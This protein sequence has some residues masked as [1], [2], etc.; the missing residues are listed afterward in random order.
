MKSWGSWDWRGETGSKIYFVTSSAAP[1][2]RVVMKTHSTLKRLLLPSALLLA[3]AASS[4]AAVSLSSY[5]YVGWGYLHPGYTS[6]SGTSTASHSDGFNDEFMGIYAGNAS[7]SAAHGALAASS[8]GAL[9]DGVQLQHIAGS[10]AG[11]EDEMTIA[12]GSLSGSGYV[13]FTVTVTATTSQTGGGVTPGANLSFNGGSLASS[14]ITGG[15]YTT[16]LIPITFGTSF[17]LSM[18]LDAES[19]VSF[20]TSGTASSSFTAALS[21]MDVYDATGTVLIAPSLYTGTAS[22]GT[23]YMLLFAVPEPSRA[24]LMLAGLTGVALRRRRQVQKQ[25]HR[26]SKSGA[27]A[28]ILPSD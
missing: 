19:L 21:G 2:E 4:H 17:D 23:N 6:A 5:A 12:G 28:M 1:C 20:T 18:G 13:M 14:V 24:M 27:F 10:S 15:T 25:V 8:D 3:L 16:A 9:A 22:S 26:R 11:F 7:A